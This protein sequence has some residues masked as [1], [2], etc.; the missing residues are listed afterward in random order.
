MMTEFRPGR[1]QILPTIIK[2]LL[3]INVLVFMAQLTFDGV[4]ANT[5]MAT[6][7][8]NF[9]NWFAL[10]NIESP[11]FK[12]W[13]MITHM[14]M[15]GSFMHLLSN[16]FGLWMFGSILE[17]IWGPK[18]FL[19]FYL[20]CGIG[21]ALVH[22][23][24][25]SWEYHSLLNDFA[26]FKNNP[27][28]VNFNSLMGNKA[29]GNVDQHQLLEISRNWPEDAEAAKLFAAGVLD[30]TSNLI[31]EIIQAPTLGASGAVFGC[32][33]A[34][35][36]LFPNTY[37]YLY[38]FVPI[39]A[40]WFVLL[41]IAFE[42]LMVLRNSAGGIARFAHIGGAVVGFLLVLFWNKTNRKQF[43]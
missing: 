15:H 5:D 38:F 22:L 18:R 24:W 42:L 35:G 7:I 3:I 32:L 40:K 31:L 29:L 11:L 37:I 19:V 9:T 23:G 43:Y 4:Q 27:N 1:F 33:A 28:I 6:K 20:I 39:K 10:H 21:A 36:Y 13:Q 2:N 25:L 34:F 41:Y 30:S 26:Q 17:N 8:G 12:P 16:M 14:F